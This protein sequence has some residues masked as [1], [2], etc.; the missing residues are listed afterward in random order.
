MR[1]MEKRRIKAC[2]FD[3]G[4][5][6]INDMRLA[7][8]AIG[9]M[10][11]WLLKESVISSRQSFLDAYGRIN[12][13]TNRPFISH[14]FGEIDFFEKTFTELAVTAM[15]PEDALKKYRD[16][17]TDKIHPDTDISA[18]L[19]LLKEKKIRIALLS[20]ET[21]RRVD[22]YLEKTDFR[23]FFDTIIVSESIGIEKPDPLIFQ[24]TLT[25]LNVASEETVMFGD[26]D[27]A[28]GASKKLG[29][30]FVLVTGYK[31]K[32]WAWEQGN[33]YQPDYVMEK[34]TKNNMATFL[35]NICLCP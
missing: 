32:D 20:N 25:R 9:D 8:D 3:L 15:S 1:R 27:I 12:H 11:D 34:I 16:I 30:F 10:A 4:N 7:H 14:T 6:L 28:D 23:R 22:A 5:T 26:N 24:E 13:H 19:Q 17:L 18:A 2:A 21:A 29:I 35:D 33:P 31:N